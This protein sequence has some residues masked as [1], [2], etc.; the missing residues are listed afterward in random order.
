MVKFRPSLRAKRSNLFDLRLPRLR[1][2]ANPRNDQ[3]HKGCLVLSFQLLVFLCPMAANAHILESNNT[4]GA[5]MHV[6]PEDDPYVGE[7][8]TLFF[9]FKD[10]ER[11]FNLDNCECT[12]AIHLQKDTIVKDKIFPESDTNTTT[13][14]Y[15]YRFP[16]KGVYVLVIDGKPRTKENFHPFTLEYEIQVSHMRAPTITPLPSSYTF[17]LS[18]DAS[19]FIG[20]FVGI[21]VVFF[22]LW[23]SRRGKKEK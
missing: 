12:L 22:Y 4:V 2:L 7:P 14:T 15:T 6:D 1:H 9:E 17:G 16:K 18:H 21:L 10:K 13:G 5:V 23:V 20:G 3:V 8:A 19:Y 11:E